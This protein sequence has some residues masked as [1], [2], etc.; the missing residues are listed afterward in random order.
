MC[1]IKKNY[2]R[3]MKRLTLFYTLIC[4]LSPIWR[5]YS[6]TGSSFT[7]LDTLIIIFY[8]LSF[9]YLFK[10]NT[11]F[12]T[13][14]GIILLY[15]LS[16]SFAVLFKTGDMSLFMRAMHQV[17]YIFFLV[18]YYTKFFDKEI[19]D[20]SIRIAGI[21]ATLFLILQHAAHIFLGLSIPGQISAF[22]VRESNLENYVV[23]S[24]VARLSS[25]FAEPSAYG[26]F[27]VLPLAIELFYRK[28]VNI[29][30]VVLFCIGCVLSTSNTALACM[31]FLLF[32]Y[33]IKNKLISWKSIVLI[34]AGFAI[35]L[36]AEQFVDA[37]RI[38]VE[39]GTSFDNR[40][41]GYRLMGYYFTNP[42]FGIGFIS[43][44][45]VGAYM[46]GFVRLV[47]YLGIVGALLYSIVYIYIYKTTNRK[48]ILFLFLFLNIGSNIFFASSV[49]FYSCFFLKN[50]SKNNINEKSI[51]SNHYIQ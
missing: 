44:E 31:V 34:I 10:N 25:F 11:S 14:Y 37:I 3:T 42:L 35:V 13:S 4:T 50:N 17:N 32:F 21:I 48:I 29:R 9:P 51:N 26:V 49:I 23:G 24:D 16:H 5:V 41:I 2:K 7:L 27:V 1:S 30:V 36:F 28:I 12:V 15:I 45:D 19:A 38:R 6:L 39:G 20:K 8:I 46:P 40:F 22:A 47:V 43:M 18:V 33:F